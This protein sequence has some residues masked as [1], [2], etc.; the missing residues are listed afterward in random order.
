MYFGP[1]NTFAFVRSAWRNENSATARQIAPL[2]ALGAVGGLV[3]ALALAPL[4]GAVGVADRHAD[5]G[6]R[7]VGAADRH[8]AGDAAAGADDHVAADLLAQDAV[9]GCRRRPLPPA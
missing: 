8:D 9:R 1:P 3:L 4:L 5:D 2:D 6:D 7:E